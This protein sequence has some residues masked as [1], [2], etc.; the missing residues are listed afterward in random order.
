MRCNI[1]GERLNPNY[2]K[3]IMVHYDV[4][5]V[6]AGLSGATIA[7]HYIRAGR[8]VL[9]IDKREHIAGNIYDEIDATTGIRVSRYGAHLF[10]T[11]DTEVWNYINRFGKFARW[12]HRVVSDVSGTLV[13]LPVNINSVN[14]LF[15]LN[16][17]TEDEMKE[18]LSD[19]RV[20]DNEIKNSED[21][22]LSR[23]G[24]R[25]YDIL[26]KDYTVKQWDKLPSEL[27]PSVLERIPVRTNFDDRYFGDRY[28]GLPLH[29]YTSL[30]ENMLSGAEVRLGVDWSEIWQKS[31]DT[32]GQLVFTGPIDVYF[33]NSNLPPLEY[34]SINFE[35][36]RIK[37]EG[38][39]QPNSVVNYPTN[40]Q[41]YTRSV[42]YKHFLNQKSDWT[43]L[44]KETTSA[45][46][47]PYYPV[48]TKENRD[49][50]LKYVGL[51]SAT[52][53]H[54][55]G[56]LASYKYFNMDQAIRN[57]MDY[58]KKYLEPT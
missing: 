56:R 27:E 28:Q 16:I 24:P 17:Q 29:G 36:H 49:L 7:E 13:P 40:E 41:K 10:H 30:V 54:F 35:W 14:T 50:Y 1:K 58:Y 33:K 34:R 45:E 6:G 44:A 23:V 32:W 3:N 22:A 47:E 20:G 38:F 39:V 12:D 19:E 42:E 11:N 37:T 57:A 31:E 51:A 25:L 53:V 48:P 26:F 55:V 5:I 21:V 15:D 18:W 2:N 4:L 8:K 9:V 43:I 52:D 46:G